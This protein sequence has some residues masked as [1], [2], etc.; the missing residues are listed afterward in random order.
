MIDFLTEH[1][2][3]IGFVIGALTA[4]IGI[5]FVIV[6]AI[7]NVRGDRS[8]KFDMAYI[9]YDELTLAIALTIC[10]ALLNWAAWF[11]II[12]VGTLVLLVIWTMKSIG[13]RRRKKR[14][15]ATR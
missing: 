8:G 13:D 11:V 2:T 3:T 6:Q 9:A 7:Q 12:P 5:T 10:L 4:A 1:H 15:L 14:W